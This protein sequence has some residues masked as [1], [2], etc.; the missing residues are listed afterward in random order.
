MASQKA[1]PAAGRRVAN[2]SMY[3]LPP[4]FRD[5]PPG[6]RTVKLSHPGAGID[7]FASAIKIDLQ[8]EFKELARLIKQG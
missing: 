4:R 2:C 8:F 5:T 7:F 1:R 3:R 6:N